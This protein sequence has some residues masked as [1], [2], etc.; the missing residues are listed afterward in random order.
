MKTIQLDDNYSVESDANNFTLKYEEK[1]TK[2]VKG[3]MKEVT[4]RDEWHYP[5]M[6]QALNRYLQESLKPCSTVF[7]VIDV[8]NRVE[9]TI[10]ELFPNS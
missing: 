4:S 3:K 5:K 2:E 6:N 10:L 7:N 8:L 9:N 1:F